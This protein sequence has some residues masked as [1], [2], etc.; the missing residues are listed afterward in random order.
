MTFGF[1][2]HFNF[3][4]AGLMLAALLMVVPCAFG[5]CSGP[6]QLEARIHAHPD[7]EIYTQLGN[8]FGDHNQFD[9]AVGAFRAGLKLEPGSAELS[10]LLGLSLFSSGHAQDAVAPLQQSIQLMPE[11]LKP[12][13]ILA[14]VFEQLQRLNEAKSEYDA[15]LHIDPHSTM[16]LK[17]LSDMLLAHQNYGA[18]IELLNSAPASEEDLRLN[19][20]LAYAKG[21]MTEDASKTLT[22]ALHAHPSSLPLTKALVTILVQ[23]TRNQE[24]V[25]LAKQCSLAHPRDL[26]AQRLYLRVLVLNDNL[27]IARPLGRK[28][29]AQAPHDFDFLYL[30]GIL[31]RQAGEYTAARD[32]LEAAVALDPNY[33]NSRYN[34]GVVLAQLKDFRGAK[35]QLEKAIA[36]GASEP[37]V[38][39][40]LATVMRNL[41]ETQEAQEQL[42]L[43]QQ[44][45]QAK[46]NR[47]VAAGKAAQAEK[48]IA[49]GDTKKA[50]ELYQDAVNATPNDALLNFKLALALDKTGD[51]TAEQTALEQAIKIDPTLALAQN[52]MGYLA[53]R[54]GDFASAEDH[55]KLAVQ[56][57]PGYAEA[58]VNLAATL[59]MES[60]LPEAQ[61]AINNAIKLDPKNSQALQLR[62]SLAKAQ[63]NH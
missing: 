2:M 58:W 42:K 22:E 10:Y 16:A 47:T 60:K 62:D 13:L 46:A 18:V 30:N 54:N 4:K 44:E 24:A 53:S 49:G 37:E 11:V 33:Y 39:F 43:Y 57:A 36:L 12:H 51:T 45:S 52:Q 38:R 15:A 14:A 34:L 3:A 8:W 35:D 26:E 6:P 59:G 23:Q 40:E 63:T 17:E 48:A 27:D 5:V 41:G 25:R 32:H 50:A 61:E 9:C 31:E 29:L 56:A 19:L 20:G 7:A 1:S 21:G 28:L 55:F